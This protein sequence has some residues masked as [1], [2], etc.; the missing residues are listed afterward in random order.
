MEARLKCIIG[1]FLHYMD[2]R[3]VR[4]SRHQASTPMGVFSR[5]RDPYSQEVLPCHHSVPRQI[6]SMT[7][8]AVELGAPA[9]RQTMLQTVRY[10]VKDMQFRLEPHYGGR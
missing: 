1:V 9:I 2:L 8:F 4:S 7:E 10:Y 3:L 6:Q 5:Y